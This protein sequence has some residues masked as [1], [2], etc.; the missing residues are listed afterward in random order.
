M[1]LVIACGGSGGHIMPALSLAAHL[2]KTL[3][4][5][6][7]FFVISRRPL[8]RKLL[9]KERGVLVLPAVGWPP[10]FS[11]KIFPFFF[12][13]FL[14]FW[15]SLFW[16]TR[17]RP[18]GFIGFGGYVTFPVMTTAFL[19]RKPV[20]LHEENVIPGRAN[21]WLSRIALFLKAP[22]RVGVAFEGSRR[23]FGRRV[24][25]AL[26][27]N[28]LR[29]DLVCL[30]PEVAR[31]FFGLDENR[32][33]ILLTGGS[34]GAHR[35]NQALVEA[36]EAISDSE[37]EEIQVIHL[38][39][40]KDAPWV[41]DRY[42]ALGVRAQVFP[43]LQ[44]IGEAYSAADLVV[45]RGGAMTLAEIGYF[46]KPALLIPLPLARNHQRE[47]VAFLADQGACLSME[48]KNILPDF[49]R[50]LLSLKKDEKKRK[51][52]SERLSSFYRSGT[53]E[54]LA[55]ELLSLIHEN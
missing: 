30:A 22:F 23:F 32:F 11:W 50:S 25:V 8:D 19:I 37:K 43:F 54:R 12:K 34:Q 48:E 53:V 46:R 3:K 26:V 10:L 9:G 2:R 15:I 20:F 33:T 29:S 24:P 52:L 38:T 49:S 27:G 18:H 28:P 5:I 41:Q 51:M 21:L 55:D 7:L 47:N 42:A 14:S 1:R 31:R 17:I 6:E 4:E 40:E 13:L 36:F 39:G 45:G 35:L 44:R 16:I